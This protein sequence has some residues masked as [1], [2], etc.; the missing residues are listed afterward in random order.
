MK[1]SLPELNLFTAKA[2]TGVSLAYPVKDWQHIMLCLSSA[3]SANFTIKIQGSFSETAPTFSAG[4]S[5]TNR[6]DY[7]QIKDLQNNAA[8]DG[9]T[10]VAFAGTD[11]VRMFE[12]NVNG[13]K[14]VSA[15]ITAISA[16]TVNLQ[17]SAFNNQ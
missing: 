12:V 9:D 4:R 11:D 5:A 8:I 3:S 13:L 10:G 1:N 15:E 6:W 17:L 14:W 16:G 7:I 2:T